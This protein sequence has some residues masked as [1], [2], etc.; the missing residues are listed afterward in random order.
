VD[1]IH[2]ACYR[3]VAAMPPSERRAPGQARAAKPNTH[4]V[5]SLIGFALATERIP[6]GKRVPRHGPGLDIQQ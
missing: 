2:P 3:K 5:S 4:F 6:V 1:A